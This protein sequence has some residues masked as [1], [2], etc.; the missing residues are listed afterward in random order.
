MEDRATC[1]AL[2][3]DDLND[4][5]IQYCQENRRDQITYQF[6]DGTCTG[7]KRIVREYLNQYMTWISTSEDS[8]VSIHQNWHCCQA[9][10]KDGDINNS[11]ELLNACDYKV[12]PFRVDYA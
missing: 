9:Y 12:E 10:D 6:K 3:E 8:S 4:P 7:E 5:F 2:S 11:E 1:C